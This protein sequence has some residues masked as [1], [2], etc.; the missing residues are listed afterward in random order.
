MAPTP[1]RMLSSSGTTTTSGTQRL[2]PDAR[3]RH[4]RPRRRLR[5]LR[6]ASQAALPDLPGR[7]PPGGA[8]RGARWRPIQLGLLPDPGGV[9]NGDSLSAWARL[10]P[11]R[12][13]QAGM[14]VPAG[15]GGGPPSG[16]TPRATRRCI[17]EPARTPHRR[18]IPLCA[19]SSASKPRAPRTPVG[20]PADRTRSTGCVTR[21]PPAPTNQPPTDRGRPGR[22]RPTRPAP[23]ADAWRRLPAGRSEA[24]VL[25]LDGLLAPWTPRR[26]S[27]SESFGMGALVRRPIYASR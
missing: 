17:L 1:S 6:H 19:T 23:A 18:L 11:R 12:S 22:G 16:C 7:C 5:R 15:S 25:E 3:L 13:G 9:S 21:H 2:P 27:E 20:R 26:E 8:P 24:G 4:R 10:G 14:G